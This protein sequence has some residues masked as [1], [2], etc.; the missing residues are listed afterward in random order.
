MLKKKCAYISVKKQEI[1][2]EKDKIVP[3]SLYAKTSKLLSIQK[4]RCGRSVSSEIVEKSKVKT[5]IRWKRG[6]NII[7]IFRPPSFDT[8]FLTAK[9]IILY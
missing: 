6:F 9:K 3:Y 5:K 4:I 2:L 1:F 8:I 7:L